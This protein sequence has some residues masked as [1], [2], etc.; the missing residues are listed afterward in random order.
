[1]R[2]HASGIGCG[3]RG[4]GS[5]PR[6][7]EARDPTGGHYDPS[8]RSSLCWPCANAGFKKRG[9]GACVFGESRRREAAMERREAPAFSKRERG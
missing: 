3:A 4:R 1:M 2:R 5:Q 7:R 9:P 6:T 8:A